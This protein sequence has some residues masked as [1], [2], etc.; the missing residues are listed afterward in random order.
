[1][2]SN[3]GRE[4][5]EGGIFHREQLF[6]TFVHAMFLIGCWNSGVTV[7]TYIGGAWQSVK[8]VMPSVQVAKAETQD[9]FSPE[10]QARIDK[11]AEWLK[12]HPM[13]ELDDSL[14]AKLPSKHKR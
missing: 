10:M 2:E 11:Q 5:R 13:P 6:W 14:D 1:M 7:T 3:Q 4:V 8:T 12:L 9:D